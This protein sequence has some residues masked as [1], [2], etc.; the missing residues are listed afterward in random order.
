MTLTRKRAT[1]FHPHILEIFDG[2]V[3]GAISKR[4]FIKQAG[5]FAA[6]GVTGAMIL[7]QLQP[8]YAW[9]AQVPADDPAIVSERISYMSPEGHGKI[10]ALMAKPAGATGKLPAVLVIHEN[11][12]LNPYIEDV[13][14]RVA[15]AG[16]LALAPDGLS[17]LGGYPGNDDEGR[18]MQRTLDGAKLMEDFFAAFEFLRDHDGSTGK[19]GAVG[20]CYGGGVCNAL[21]VAYPDLA[22]SVPYYGRQPEAADVPAIEAPLMVQLAGLDERINAGWPAYEAALE[23]HQKEYSVHFYPDVNHGFHN[24]TTPRYD[25]KAATL[26]WQR[27]LAF[28]DTHLRG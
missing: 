12:G 7:D 26:S 14:R 16:Y 13:A 18:T 3:H 24:D 22:A 5:K 25:E 6:A 19:V 21:A 27:T 4:E 10:R 28:F 23:E 15:K 20:F 11:R 17:P 8:D 2:Y 9:A 1:D